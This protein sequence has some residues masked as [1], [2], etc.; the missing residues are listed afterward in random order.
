ML[1]FAVNTYSVTHGM[2]VACINTMNE[3]TEW[4]RRATFKAAAKGMTAYTIAL[5][6]QPILRWVDFRGSTKRHMQDQF[7]IEGGHL[8]HLTGQML[9]SALNR[10][11]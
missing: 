2:G 11:E 6:L 3:S 7:A 5:R 10:N 1:S 4:Q 9:R 8:R